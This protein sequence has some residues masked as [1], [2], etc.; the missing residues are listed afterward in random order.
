MNKLA[1]TILP[2]HPVRTTSPI[3]ARVWCLDGHVLHI[4]P[5]PLIPQQSIV[6]H[7]KMDGSTVFLPSLC[8]VPALSQLFTQLCCKDR[9][10]SWEGW[11]L[12]SRIPPKHTLC[13]RTHPRREPLSGVECIHQLLNFSSRA[14][15]V[16]IQ[17]LLKH[18]NFSLCK[19]L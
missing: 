4:S 2:Q 3:H 7:F 11:E 13:W 10:L 5:L 8:P 19:A 17:G 6:T 15:G 12:Q 9:L 14:T 16:P 18:P 1:P